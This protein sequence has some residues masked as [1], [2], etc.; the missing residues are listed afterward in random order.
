MISRFI[1]S[2]IAVVC[3]SRSA[4]AG[5]IEI[6]KDSLPP[7]ALSGSAF[8]TVAGQT[9]T[10]EAPVGACTM[11]FALPDGTNLVT[12]LTSAGSTLFSVST[13]PDS[14][15]DWFDLTTGTAAVEIVPGDMFSATVVT[16]T[17]IAAPIAVQI[18]EPGTAWSLGLGLG[19][20]AVYRNRSKRRLK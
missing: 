2:A 18:P 13:F 1:W 16:F 5:Y 6:C 11:P 3:H 10:Y 12:E 8:F 17:N 9:G 14:R 19:V 4:L 7:T 20:W 15:L